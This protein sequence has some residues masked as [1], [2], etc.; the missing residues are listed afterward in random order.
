[1]HT[2]PLLN[3]YFSKEVYLLSGSLSMSENWNKSSG[4]RIH[5]FSGKSVV[6]GPG[7]YYVSKERVTISTLLGSC[8]ALC[9]WDSTTGII[10]MNHYLLARKARSSAAG[11]GLNETGRYGIQ[12][13]RLL[14]NGMMKIGAQ[15]R[16]LKAK[17]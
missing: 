6:I 10:G 16:H 8:V 5:C 2:A 1:M 13:V 3:D 7:Q 12:T 14:I 9:L 15:R 11:G 17:V 4:L